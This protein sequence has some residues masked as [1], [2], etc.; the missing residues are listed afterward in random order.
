MANTCQGLWLQ[1]FTTSRTNV[2]THPEFT[3]G[4][5]VMSTHN[6]NVEQN[7]TFF[8]R[9]SCTFTCSCGNHDFMHAAAMIHRT[10]PATGM[11]FSC[12]RSCVS[13]HLASCILDMNLFSCVAPN[14]VFLVLSDTT[15]A[16]KKSP[17]SSYTITTRSMRPIRLPLPQWA[18]P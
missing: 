13:V 10:V 4:I 9:N 11:L 8:I 1:I 2:T 17:F 18:G 12:K 15:T 16:S 6:W 3:A 7:S 14:L 5:R